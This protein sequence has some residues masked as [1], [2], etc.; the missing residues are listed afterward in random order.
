[1]YTATCSLV[2]TGDRTSFEMQCNIAEEIRQSNG[3]EKPVRASECVERLPIQ[4]LLTGEA[5]SQ[6][7]QLVSPAVGGLTISSI[8]IAWMISTGSLS[9]DVAMTASVE[10]VATKCAMARKSDWR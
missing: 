5:S 9:R 1:M 7:L 2:G 8:T 6:Q 4:I 10:A 3:L